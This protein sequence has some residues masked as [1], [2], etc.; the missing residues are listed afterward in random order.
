MDR[1]WLRRFELRRSIRRL[2]RSA[3]VFVVKLDQSRCF[4][5]RLLDRTGCLSWK[6]QTA[7]RLFCGGGRAAQSLFSVAVGRAKSGRCVLDLALQDS[8]LPARVDSR[9]PARAFGPY[10]AARC[11]RDLPLFSNGRHVQAHER[12]VMRRLHIIIL[13]A[14]MEYTCLLQLTFERSLRLVFLEMMKHRAVS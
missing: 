5:A 14:E 1:I 7:H 4:S 8:R 3:R 10:R 6:D 12:Q 9:K 2:A 13:R 11:R